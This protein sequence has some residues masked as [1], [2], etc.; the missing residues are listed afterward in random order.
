MVNK[1]SYRRE[2]KRDL[3]AR[4]SDGIAQEDRMSS[5]DRGKAEGNFSQAQGGKQIG[6]SFSGRNPL[7][8]ISALGPILIIVVILFWTANVS[9]SGAQ[10]STEADSYIGPLPDDTV[11]VEWEQRMLPRPGLRCE[12]LGGMVEPEIHA[13]A[14]LA[15]F[16]D[17]FEVA[18][19]KSKDKQLPFASIVKL[20]GALVV[21]HYYA[22]D[23]TIGL[24]DA[25]DVE[26]NG[27][28]LEVGEM[29]SVEDLL[30]AALIGSKNDAMYALAQNYEGG[31]AGFVSEMNHTAEI[32]GMEHTSIQNVI[33][34][35]SPEQ[36]STAED[37]AILLSA[38][39]KDPVLKRFL[40]IA[41]YTVHTSYGR[42]EVIG[43]TNAL[44]GKVDGVIAGKTGYTGDAGLSLVAYVDDDPDFITVVFDAEDRYAETE[45]L[46][47]AVRKNYLCR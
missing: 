43:T 40:S 27:M 17:S 4:L 5:A 32:L 13:S 29:A 30:S 11:V 7:S 15:V 28:D 3:L 36:Y 10:S 35:D 9:R 38:V 24:L 42:D 46:I 26:G 37:V 31:Q 47:T 18:F 20:V 45:K 16:T 21:S 41:S 25:V 8:S 39:M 22:M 34:L 14:Y 12:R 33:G 23:S 44:L 2:K 1:D 19:E 6:K